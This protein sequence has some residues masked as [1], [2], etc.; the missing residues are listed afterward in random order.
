MIFFSANVI[1]IT[2]LKIFTLT[3]RPSQVKKNNNLPSETVM[4]REVGGAM[5]PLWNSYIEP[6]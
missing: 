4:V 6:G 2:A 1:L 3:F 5:A